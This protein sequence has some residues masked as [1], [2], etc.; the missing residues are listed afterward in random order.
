MAGVTIR[1]L[2]K[3]YGAQ[4]VIAGL[5]LDIPD[6]AFVVLVGPSGCGK[7]TAL[8]ILAG[9]EQPVR[10][11]VRV[12][13]RAS[14]VFQEASVFPWM[15]VE[16]NVGYPLRM[17][18]VRGARR[19]EIVEP[20]LELTGLTDFRRAFPHQL[21]G[22]M[23]QRT[24]VARALADDGEVLLMD[25]P[26]GALDEQTRVVLQQELLRVWGQTGK[27]VV[28]ITHSVD[29][30]LTLADRVLVM[31]A[32]PGRIVASLEVPFGRPRDV[33]ELRRDPGF[34]ALTYEVW[35][36]LK[37]DETAEAAAAEEAEA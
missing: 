14:M 23:K 37:P 16:D 17:R 21:S 33:L 8:R 26:F 1:G 12:D 30:A 9:L 2:A 27:T 13:G 10:G 19:R 18:G 5:S 36:L 32:R 25:E 24:S 3:S 4:Q 34:G 28:F 35:R 7:T 11:E 22:G 20:L 15:T 29:E 6:G 31:S